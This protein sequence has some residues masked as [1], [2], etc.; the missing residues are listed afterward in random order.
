MDDKLFLKSF[1][2]PLPL[3]QSEG[4]ELRVNV[5]SV[6]AMLAPLPDDAF[7]PDH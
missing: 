6:I 5:L 2:M 3:Q 7:G 4:G 1:G